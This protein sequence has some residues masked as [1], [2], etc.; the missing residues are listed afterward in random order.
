MISRG[1]LSSSDSWAVMPA[2]ADTGTTMHNME[3]YYLQKAKYLIVG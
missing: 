3:K 2:H 1:A